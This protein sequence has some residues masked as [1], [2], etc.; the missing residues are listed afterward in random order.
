MMSVSFEITFDE[1]TTAEV[2]RPCV[3]VISIE[4]GRAPVFA[5]D[6]ATRIHI[7]IHQGQFVLGR[8]VPIRISIQTE[9]CTQ[10]SRYANV[11]T[12]GRYI[13]RVLSTIAYCWQGRY[14]ASNAAPLGKT[15]IGLCGH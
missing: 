2:L 8:Q 12:C 5:I 10:V 13:G 7:R 9:V 6:K 1:P 4:L 11:C 3:V 14:I 15:L